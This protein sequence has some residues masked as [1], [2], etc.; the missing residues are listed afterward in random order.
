M[1]NILHLSDIH[2]R[3]D[4]NW[5][6]SRSR[7]HLLEIIKNKNF[8][9][10]KIDIIVCTGDI[11]FGSIAAQSLTDQYKEALKFFSDL[12]AAAGIEDNMLFIVPG[13]HD[14]DRRLTNKLAD[15]ALQ[16]MAIDSRQNAKEVNN[17]VANT[18]REY[19][20]SIQRLDEY[21]KFFLEICPH[22]KIKEPHLHYIY[23]TILNGI[24]IHIIGLNSAWC[25][26]GAEDYRSIWI[27]A[28]AQLAGVS[29]EDSI[30]IALMH[31]PLDWLSK[32]DSLF[33]EGRMGRDLHLLLHGHEHEFHEC[34]YSSSPVIG[35][36][37]LSTDA[38]P[39]HG[40]LLA[41]IEPE[42]GIINKKILKYSHY[43]GEWSI[44]N[45]HNSESIILPIKHIK[46]N[47]K[48]NGSKQYGE[49]FQRPNIAPHQ[50]EISRYE[51]EIVPSSNAINRNIE[52]FKNLWLDCMGPHTVEELRGD[53]NLLHF[54]GIG[55]SSRIA[56]PGSGLANQHFQ[57][58]FAR[59]ASNAPSPSL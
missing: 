26:N 56:K 21:K 17:Y 28:Q 27:G 22:I 33:I 37:A 14:V 40:I 19:S 42:K 59:P 5:S 49:S 1:I 29:R 45:E 43:Y 34:S 6:E 51:Q 3:F 54:E 39:N 20:T 15:N 47:S 32:A 38:D 10:E 44:S 12:K 13:N 2:F 23:S 50:G 8:G 48:I 41:E 11:A 57:C 46:H 25:C 53:P 16:Q 24:K 18:Q 55:N 36:G 31:H 4:T 52:H 58:R 7:E 35:V 30:R 9:F